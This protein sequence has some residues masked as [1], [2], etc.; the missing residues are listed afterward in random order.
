MF[1][2]T[3][4]RTA[5]T[6]KK[7]QIHKTSIPFISSLNPFQPT[8]TTFLHQPVI[9]L[10]TS[11]KK[12]TS[13]ILQ[14]EPAHEQTSFTFQRNSQTWHFSHSSRLSPNKLT[15]ITNQNSSVPL[16]RNHTYPKPKLASQNSQKYLSNQS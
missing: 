16:Y 13:P 1:L 8:K 2:E 9:N 11:E 3:A 15:T 10:P 6:S 7:L 4:E 12:N 5:Q 14:T